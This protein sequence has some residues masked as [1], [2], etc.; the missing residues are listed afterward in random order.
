MSYHNQLREEIHRH[1]DS[2]ASEGRPWVATWIANSIC[3][4]HDAGLTGNEDAD[5]WRHCGYQETREQVRACI[6]ARA[7]DRPQPKSEQLR[8]AGWNHLQAY[9]LVDRE[10]PGTGVPVQDMTD[11]EL[12]KKAVEY[13]T[14][15]ATCFAHADELDQ[16]RRDRR[17]AFAA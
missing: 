8:F 11:E 1:L 3:N 4:N 16:F 7:G 9:Y 6:N 12:E 10:E 13:R 14:M 2:L 5:F 15:G 17:G